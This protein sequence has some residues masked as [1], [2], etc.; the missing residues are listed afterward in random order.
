MAPH[1]RQPKLDNR[2]SSRKR[3]LIT[4]PELLRRGRLRHDIAV[5]TE[6]NP[7]RMRRRIRTVSR[8]KVTPAAIPNLLTLCNGICGLLSILFATNAIVELSQYWSILLAGSFVFGGMFFDMMDGQVARRLKQSSLFG[9]QLDSLSD[10]VTFGAAPVFLLLAFNDYLPK[11]ALLLIGVTH[12][13]CAL[14]RLARFNVQTDETDTHE[15]FTG[16]PSPAAAGVIA[17][18]A[19]ALVAQERWLEEETFPWYADVSPTITSIMMILVPMIALIGSLLMVSNICYRHVANQWRK[20]KMRAYQITRTVVI[21]VTAIVC[22]ILALPLAFCL[23]AFEAP[24][25]ALYRKVTGT[26]S[27]AAKAKEAANANSVSDPSVPS[28]IA[29]LQA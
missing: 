15:F 25:A 22:G 12:F 7:L 19:L 29:D 27:P 23:F 9:A 8:R 21:C 28:S 20:R 11:P 14:L 2:R 10:A 26:P 6:L 24:F 3:R 5:Q 17:S 16:L 18:F 13:S 4:L 1:L